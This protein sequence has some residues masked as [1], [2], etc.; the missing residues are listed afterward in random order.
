MIAQT[1]V[2]AERLSRIECLICDIVNI[3]KYMQRYELDKSLFIYICIY[4]LFIHL[5]IY[6]LF[7]I[8]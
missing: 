7:P 2:K 6:L 8:S 3:W 1:C 4:L 5:F